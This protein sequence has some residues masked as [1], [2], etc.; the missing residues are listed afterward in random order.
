MNRI[1][2]DMAARVKALPGTGYPDD[3]PPELQQLCIVTYRLLLQGA[4][5]P[6][7]DIAGASGLAR[8]RELATA[9]TFL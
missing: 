6:P 7:G 5:I 3:N 8:S 2:Q 4:P 9:R 1:Q